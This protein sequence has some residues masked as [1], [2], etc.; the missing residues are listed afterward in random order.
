MANAA[1]II[2]IFFGIFGGYWFLVFLG[3]C[4][5]N[6]SCFQV[7]EREASVRENCGKAGV[8]LTPG[9]YCLCPIIHRR[10]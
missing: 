7:R 6:C 8:I 1:I 5:S 4:C 3:A 2:A 10:R 9:W